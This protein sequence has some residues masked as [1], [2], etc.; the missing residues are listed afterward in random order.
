MLKGSSKKSELSRASIIVL[1]MP[2]KII[3]FV[4]S[5]LN[6]RLKIYGKTR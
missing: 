4:S 6:N 5:L 2:V 3:S 1:E